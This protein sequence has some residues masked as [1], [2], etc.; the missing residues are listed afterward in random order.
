MIKFCE[1]CDD[2][3]D[4]HVTRSCVWCKLG[5]FPVLFSC[6]D[7]LRAPSSDQMSS[8]SS[9]CPAA[10][11]LHHHNHFLHSNSSVT[12]FRQSLDRN[13]Y[14]A[15]WWLGYIRSIRT[16]IRSGTHELT[17]FRPCPNTWS[18]RCNALMLYV[19]ICLAFMPLASCVQ[20]NTPPLGSTDAVP[21]VQ[22]HD[23]M[24]ESLRSYPRATAPRFLSLRMSDLWE[25]W[26]NIPLAGIVENRQ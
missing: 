13:K 18:W 9:P 16:G 19:G 11:P 17:H 8:F 23:L 20:S 25:S 10:R 2:L 12:I 5:D 3:G 14:R 24:N 26:G 4:R 1:C 21:W 7:R 6:T 22:T 15:L